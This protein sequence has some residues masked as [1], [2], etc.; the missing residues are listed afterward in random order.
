[1]GNPPPESPPKNNPYCVVEYTI[2]ARVAVNPSETFS[3]RVRDTIT[4][5]LFNASRKVH[6]SFFTAM[7]DGSIR[8][9]HIQVP[10]DK[11]KLQ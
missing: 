7:P 9:D 3:D 2:A 6:E 11:K 1:M 10:K 4:K 5:V 8:M